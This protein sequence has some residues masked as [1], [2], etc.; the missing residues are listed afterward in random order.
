MKIS[1]YPRI[2]VSKPIDSGQGAYYKN[3][4][5]LSLDGGWL[6][7]NIPF[8]FD[9]FSGDAYNTTSLKYTLVPLIA[10]LRWQMDDVGGPWVFR[11]NWDLTARASVVLIPRRT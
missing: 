9:G 10:S 1:N 6:P 8:V 5:E 4:V 2:Q 7:I 11:G 3:K